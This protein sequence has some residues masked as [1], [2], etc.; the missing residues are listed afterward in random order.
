MIPIK[1]DMTALVADFVHDL[2]SGKDPSHLGL[3]GGI[4][5]SAEIPPGNAYQVT[6]RD[7]D[8][9]HRHHWSDPGVWWFGPHH[10]IDDTDDKYRGATPYSWGHL[11]DMYGPLTW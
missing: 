11:N 9:W 2:A 4:L 7:G 10:D 6:D 3:I 1:M 8:P 5:A